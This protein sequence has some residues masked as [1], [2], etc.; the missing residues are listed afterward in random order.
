MPI[1]FWIFIVAGYIGG[2]ALSVLWAR[3]ALKRISAETPYPARIRNAGIIA[4]AV[5]TLPAL[6]FATL[7][8]G[9]LGG[10]IAASVATSITQELGLRQVVTGFG[11]GCGVL[12]VLAVIVVSTVV[13]G[14]VFMKAYLA[15]PPQ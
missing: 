5:A 11:I 9:N 15:R 8:G 6:F 2:T 1:L 4:G 14:A 7:L 3:R 13:A 10:A 12:T